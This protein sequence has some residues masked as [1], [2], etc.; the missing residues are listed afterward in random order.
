M[1]TLEQNALEN[2][3]RLWKDDRMPSDKDDKAFEIFTLEQILK[4][5]DLSDEEIAHGNTGGGGDGGVDGFLFFIDRQLV[6]EDNFTPKS[7]M[8]AEL[9]LVQSTRTAGFDE[10]KVDKLEKFCHYLLDWK[11]LGA[12]KNLSQTAKDNMMR[13]RVSYEKL[14]PHEHT[15]S[16]NLHYASRSNHPPSSNVL[17]RIDE[18]KAYIKSKLSLANVSFIPWGNVHL[19]EAL[20]SNPKK[21][22]ILRKIKDLSMAD[23]SIVCLCTVS[24]FAAFLDDG[25]GNLMTWIMEPNVRDYLGNNQVNKQIRSTLNSVTWTE[26]FWWL[27]NGVTIL[28]DSCTS[29]GDKVTIDN[30]EIVNGLQTS[31]EIFKARGN[32]TLADRHVLVKVIVAP[33][34]R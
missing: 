22:L 34:D 29:A 32:Q 6:R 5:K 26:D 13:F 8:S 4:D 7:A 27:N 25:K 24:D 18:L 11:D 14:L 12:Q 3:F 17:L 10:G 2:A 1:S 30:P 23:S 21:K 15:L 20:R 33:D 31:Y 28:A 9:T 16:V 19:M